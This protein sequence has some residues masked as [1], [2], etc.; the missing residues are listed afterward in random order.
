MARAQVTACGRI[1]F[2][3]QNLSLARERLYGGLG[4]SL[5]E[6]RVRIEA[7][8]A[9]EL[10]CDD[11]NASEY[12][13]H[14]LDLL[15]LPGIDL[16]V[17]ERLPAHVGLGSGT[18][19]ALATLAAVARAHDRE[20][21]VMERAPQLGRGGR[22]GVG[23]ATFESGGFVV[24]AGH[25]AE[26]FTTQPPAAGEWEVPKPV[27]RHAL[28]DSWQFVV[29]IPNIGPGRSDDH[30]DRSIERVVEHADPAVADDI[31]RIVAQRLLPAVAEDDWHEFGD[32]IAAVSR[33]NGAWYA[34]EQGGVYR[35]P[36]GELI[37]VLERSPAVAGAGQSSWGPA[38]YGLTDDERADT[39]R[40]AAREALSAVGVD[41]DVMVC[42]PD[43]EGARIETLE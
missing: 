16:T 27:A 37:D 15:D 18:R 5:H 40:T 22:S 25:P 36:L 17:H 21:R 10:R 4:V 13:A 39:A 14:A 42:A 23:C 6:P 11:P 9:D 41:G 7:S 35:P 31:A 1:H 33:L 24:D 32:A 38:V 30:E 12:A 8:P 2:G 19:L 28:A 20:P 3:F 43:N 29:A 34:D 26:R